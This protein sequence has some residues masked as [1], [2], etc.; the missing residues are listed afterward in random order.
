MRST[1]PSGRGGSSLASLL[2]GMNTAALSRISVTLNGVAELLPEDGDEASWCKARHLENNTFE[3]TGNNIG[4]GIF[5]G[6][7]ESGSMPDGDGGAGCY[8]EGEEVRVVVV[9]IKDGR[10]ADWKGRVE[11]W[12]IDGDG[13]QM[14]N[15]A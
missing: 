5:G 11:D 15:G 6:A 12:V 4:T 3:G 9:R 14:V 10:I 2:L 1:S 8:I 7:A 13:R